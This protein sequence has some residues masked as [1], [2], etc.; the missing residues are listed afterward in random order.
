MMDQL[1][2]E[3]P[4]QLKEALEIGRAATFTA[5]EHP[6]QHIVVAGMGGSG[7]GANF[8]IEFTAEECKLPFAVAKGYRLPGHVNE[9]TLV[10]CS[11]YSGNTEET[12]ECFE[13][14]IA[15]KAKVVV[16]ASGGK[17]LAKAREHGL[18]HIAIPAGKPS[19]RACLGY[20]FVQQLFVLKGFGIV[21]DKAINAVEGSI[22]LLREEQNDLRQRARAL[23]T[24]LHGKTPILYATDRNEPI[25]VR[26]RQQI[27]EN[28]KVLCWHH[29]FPEMCHNELVGWREQNGHFA[30]L[31][32]RDRDDYVRNQARIDICKAVFEEYAE[33]ILEVWSKGENLVE[34]SMYL[35]HLGDWISWYLAELRGVDAVE[36]KAID[37]L[38]N[39]LSKI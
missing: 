13:D 2:L 18:D 29:S 19:P 30:V 37:F 6:I 16:I 38:K 25:L 10:I 27:N 4:D 9:H 23:A 39:E 31:I 22:A 26:L 1:I 33:A 8:C 3:F 28:A 15:R 17:L 24:G 34:R 5:P 36:V 11:S 7:I 20:S 35:V 12:L 32:F 21:S 14:A